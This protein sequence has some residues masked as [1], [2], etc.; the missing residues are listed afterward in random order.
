M[1]GRTARRR[2]RGS[3]AVSTVLVSGLAGAVLLSGSDQPVTAHPYPHWQEIAG[4]PLSPRT[5]ALGVHVR[6]RVL[7]L[8]G[9]RAGS[10]VRDGAAYDLRTGIWRHL[11]T[12]VA[13]T[14]RDSAVV[15]AGV[16]V[17][18]QVRPGRPAAWWRYGPLDNAWSRMNDLP[19]HLAAPSAFG[20]EVY[21]LSG[22]H[23]VVY[24]IQLGRWTP[25]PTDPIRPALVRRTV[26]ASRSGTLVTGYAAAHPR[27]LLADRW[28]GL[29]WRRSRSPTG[30]PVTAAP[31][32]A[33]R[34]RVG[35]RTLVV[36]GD[37][38]WIRLP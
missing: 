2:L 37:H 29:R 28:D 8:G 9:V 27:R 36:R 25:L 23:V 35:G 4:P 18:R 11:R 13:V 38:A 7:V 3:A 14:D 33:T 10:V 32:G 17:L 16:V 34:V 12:P 22:R 24:S 6:H 20:S 15:A 21:A 19:S 5:H 31:N 26:T 30:P 1:T